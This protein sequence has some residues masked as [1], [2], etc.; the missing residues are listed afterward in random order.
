M[1]TS[2]WFGLPL[3]VVAGVFL[4]SP[5]GA[6][7]AADSSSAS[8]PAGG[9]QVAELI[10][11]LGAEELGPQRKAVDALVELG[12]A[13]R[14]Q[15]EAVLKSE[16]SE[17]SDQQ[18]ERINAILIDD[19]EIIRLEKKTSLAEE[20][21]E[22]L[23]ILRTTP[24]SSDARYKVP[25]E[26]REI[27]TEAE[28][29]D[30]DLALIVHSM[31]SQLPARTD[32][33][34][35]RGFDPYMVSDIFRKIIEHAH[36]GEATSRAFGR[37]V[38]EGYI[39]TMSPKGD[40]DQ[41]RPGGGQESEII[42]R[43][44]NRDALDAGTFEQLLDAFCQKLAVKQSSYNY[45]ELRAEPAVMVG[46]VYSRHT[47]SEHLGR[48]AQAL[49][50]QSLSGDEYR[51]YSSLAAEAMKFIVAS[52][53]LTEVQARA[54][55]TWLLRRES[56]SRGSG[57]VGFDLIS[58]LTNHT[59][60]TP[61]DL[62]GDYTEMMTGKPIQMAMTRWREWWDVNRDKPVLPRPKEPRYRYVAADVLIGED[63]Q[64]I[65]QIVG[66]IILE[67]G[68]GHVLRKAGSDR[69]IW[70][71]RQA[72]SMTDLY[73]GSSSLMAKL[74]P[75]GVQLSE[76]NFDGGGGYGGGSGMYPA[77][78]VK[79]SGLY[80]SAGSQ[81]ALAQPPVVSAISGTVRVARV[82]GP[83]SQPSAHGRTACA[84][85]VHDLAQG[86]GPTAGQ[87]AD[88]SFWI[89]G[90]VKSAADMTRRANTREARRIAMS[91][92]Y[93]EGAGL[94][95]LEQY[96]MPL[97]ESA[98]GELLK[99][100]DPAV[101]AA[102]ALVLARWKVEVDA[103]RLVELLDVEDDQASGWAAEALARAGRP[104]GVRHLLKHLR[105]P[106]YRGDAHG[107]LMRL[108]DEGQFSPEVKSKLAMDIITTLLPREDDPAR[109]VLMEV[110]LAQRWTGEDF[111][112]RL[113]A[114]PEKNAAA[115]ARYHQ[116]K[117]KEQ[118]SDDR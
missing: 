13:A 109:P 71:C 81:R 74:V 103:A 55:I 47:T 20:E 40:G 17:L 54:I 91:L 90:A 7:F 85:F 10:K 16:D 70:V 41:T 114:E 34:E 108:A 45:D 88:P 110:L 42:K 95:Q 21:V 84:V 115:L 44:L 67:P 100:G 86:S 111:G 11:Q 9:G 32:S 43:L 15:L 94:L 14:P 39:P 5:T 107:M 2:T 66:D 77:G 68:I 22:A 75:D 26:L 112:Y 116:W 35:Q 92:G 72:S 19:G 65:V 79:F 46:L 31:L 105:N 4:V 52:P 59:V 106:E 28:R 80:S 36:A 6:V 89:K 87:L 30:E 50:A 29:T 117:G 62:K 53:K 49:I 27:A 38:R 25:Q 61:D 23:Q 93:R 99:D 56:D 57:I 102:A 113:G 8:A 73:R 58:Q 63:D 60:L 48:L 64:S 37:W 104:E 76:Y 18:K 33:G 51:G 118:T 83:S 78:A 101:A 1:K 69:V 24:L 98:L 12:A 97:V 82:G 96:R 3:T